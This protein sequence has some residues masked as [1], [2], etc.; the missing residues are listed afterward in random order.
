MAAM[1][2][3]LVG[4]M[5][6]VVIIETIDRKLYNSCQ[7]GQFRQLNAAYSDSVMRCGVIL[8]RNSLHQSIS[9]AALAKTGIK[10]RCGFSRECGF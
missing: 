4:M 5:M 7:F 9:Q 2:M 8:P 3:I 1:K 6:K 10:H